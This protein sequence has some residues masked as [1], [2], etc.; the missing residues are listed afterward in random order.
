MNPMISKIS[1][2]VIAL[3]LTGISAQAQG[4]LLRKLQEKTE[5]KI[6]NEILGEPDKPEQNQNIPDNDQSKGVQNRRGSG[7]SQDAPDVAANIEEA[8]KHFDAQRYIQAKSSVRNALW[9]VELEIGKKVLESL[10]KEV[11]NLT[12]QE[13]DDK[14]SSTG[15]GFAGLVIERTYEGDDDMQLK[16][17]IGNDSALLGMA[18]F[19]MVDGA[20][21][22]SSEQPDQKQVQFKDHRAVIRYDEYDGYTL[23]VPFG[24]TSIF[25]VN[26]VNFENE[27]D[28]MAAANRFDLSDIKSKLGV[29]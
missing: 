26:G 21:M 4:R 29:Q 8:E 19:Y 2:L 11:V 1:M 18:G 10:P 22:Q 16:A 14:V 7:L 9:G 12:A 25:I 5:E 28:F 27:P 23:S 6:V 13:S 24:Q 15:V 3:C 17:T 20:Y